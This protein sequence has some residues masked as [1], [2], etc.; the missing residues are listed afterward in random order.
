MYN[1]EAFQRLVS[2]YGQSGTLEFLKNS[3]NKEN[4][5]EIIKVLMQESLNSVSVSTIY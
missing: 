2:K 4:L 1:F 5:L 3:S